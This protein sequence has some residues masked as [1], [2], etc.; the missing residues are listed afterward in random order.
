LFDYSSGFTEEL[1]AAQRAALVEDKH[2][3]A[4]P[5]N[6]WLDIMDMLPVLPIV[7]CFSGNGTTFMAA[8]QKGLVC[9][10]NEQDP[11]YCCL[12]LERISTAFPDIKITKI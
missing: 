7:D 5:I 11:S 8:Q 2:P 12:I 4:K 10:G 1:R 9:Y 3:P 6:L